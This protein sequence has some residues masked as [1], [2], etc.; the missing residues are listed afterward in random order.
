MSFDGDVPA[1]EFRHGTTCCGPCVTPTGVLIA[2]DRRATSGNLIS[3]RSLEK[4]F[5]PTVTAVWRS[6]A[7]PAPPSKWFAFS[8]CSWSTTR[9]S[10]AGSLS[11][12]GKAN[13]LSQM[14]RN[15]LPAA[16]QGLAV[17]PI[18]AGFDLARNE[19]RL[20]AYD[21]TGGRYEETQQTS[22]GSGSLH[23]GSVLKLGYRDD[24]DE[25]TVTDLVIESLFEAADED[26]AT[27][28]PRPDPRHLSG[29]GHHHRRRLH[30]RRRPTVGRPHPI[31]HRRA[32]R[33][34]RGKCHEHAFLRGPRAGHEGPCRLR[35]QG[36][37]PRSE[38]YRLSFRRRDRDLCRKHLLHAAK[39]QRDL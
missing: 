4:V 2:G 7:P 17:V 31:A 8:N 13:Q 14:I 26:S 6:L 9:R 19:G 12:E 38:P 36:H 35:P 32:V 25:S 34:V 30:P 1:R 28:R 3:H 24:L 27:R 29:G 23:A 39:D 15:N 10:R 21:I 11:L 18:F 33:A 16:M 5:R 37:R 20:F 22:T